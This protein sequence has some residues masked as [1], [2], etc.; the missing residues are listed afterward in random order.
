M[1]ARPHLFTWLFMVVTLAILTTGGK[2]LYWLPAVMLIWANLHG[3]FILG[4]VLQVI[5]I[6]GSVLESYWSPER[7]L[8]RDFTQTKKPC[9]G[10][11]SQYPCYRFESFWL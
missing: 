1:A 11:A 8:L 7:S 2:R 5:F 9:T 10:S 3:G 6:V 4:L